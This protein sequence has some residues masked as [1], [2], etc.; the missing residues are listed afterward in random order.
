[1][2]I[3]CLADLKEVQSSLAVV[4]PAYKFNSSLLVCGYIRTINKCIPKEISQLCINYYRI[5]KRI[6]IEYYNKT[7]SKSTFQFSIFN[8]KTKHISKKININILSSHTIGTKSLCYIPNI[9]K[10][11]I[12]LPSQAIKSLGMD[13]ENKV[14]D[15]FVTITQVKHGFAR[16]GCGHGQRYKHYLAFIFYESIFVY[17]TNTNGKI[18]ISSVQTKI[19]SSYLRN[20]KIFNNDDSSILTAKTFGGET[21]QK[22]YALN[23]HDIK[24]VSFDFKLDKIL[25]I[26]KVDIPWLSYKE[27]GDMTSHEKWNTTEFPMKEVQNLRLN[28]INYHI[29][30]WKCSNGKNLACLAAA[31][32]CTWSSHREVDS[33]TQTP[34]IYNHELGKIFTTWADK[35]ILSNDCFWFDEDNS[36][37]LYWLFEAHKKI[38]LYRLDINKNYK[39]KAIYKLDFGDECIATTFDYF[40]YYLP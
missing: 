7:T 27:S 37:I 10:H 8:P 25:Q 3:T 5:S 35:M 16:C 20:I 30:Q 24:S 33:A 32:T 9:S 26:Q 40:F 22:L 39:W 28:K 11:L 2:S 21:G 4:E 15:G 36:N 13:F 17:N 12:N 1:M 6:F 29:K 31:D 34:M 38:N 14:Y 19:A 18:L 23:L